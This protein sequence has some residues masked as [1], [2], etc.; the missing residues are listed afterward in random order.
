LDVGLIV[1]PIGNED[2]AFLL[3]IDFGLFHPGDGQKG[4]FDGMD[5]MVA[6][7]SLNF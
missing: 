7:H 6:G 4:F 2:G 1:R 3:Q 5:A